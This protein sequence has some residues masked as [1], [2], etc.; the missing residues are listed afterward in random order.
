MRQFS[1][2]CFEKISYEQHRASRHDRGGFIG[3]QF[4]SAPGRRGWLLIAET[5]VWGPATPSCTSLRY[6][7][8]PSRSTKVIGE[9][10]P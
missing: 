2:N 10:S 3:H 6:S 9:Y 5:L 1:P 7:V 8:D 4:R